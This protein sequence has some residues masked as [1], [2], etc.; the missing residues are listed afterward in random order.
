MNTEKLEKVSTSAIKQKVMKI[1]F[2][3]CD[4]EEN[5]EL[6]NDLLELCDFID[7]EQKNV[8][9]MKSFLYELASK[10]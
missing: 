8:D 3:H 4:K 6:Y 10:F 2:K 1:M 9:T 5:Q 7:D